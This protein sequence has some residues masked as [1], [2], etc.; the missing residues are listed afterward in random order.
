MA[1]LT[2]EAFLAQFTDRVQVAPEDLTP[3]YP[4]H[5]KRYKVNIFR[6]LTKIIVQKDDGKFY[7]TKIN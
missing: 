7:C 5:A 6:L 4:D 2:R 1:T 3:T